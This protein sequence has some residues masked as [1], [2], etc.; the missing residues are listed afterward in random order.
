MLETC[1]GHP[2][3]YYEKRE[4]NRGREE[5]RKVS[6]FQVANAEMQRMWKGLTQYIVVERERDQAKEVTF[7][8]T[9]LEVKE[10]EYFYKLIR[11]HWG[12]ENGLHRVKDVIHHKDKNQIRD[13]TGATIASL[14]SSIAINISRKKQ[15]QSISYSKI[16]FRSNVREALRLIR[17]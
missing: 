12:I 16:F 7:Y 17:T 13:R 10:A 1:T 4:R 6:V 5:C 9:N 3:A 8:I 2:S 15:E 11:S 14:M